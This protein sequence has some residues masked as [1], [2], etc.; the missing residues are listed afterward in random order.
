MRAKAVDQVVRL[1]GD[2]R[3][4]DLPTV[5]LALQNAVSAHDVKVLTHRGWGKPHTLSKLVHSQR[6]VEKEFNKFDAMRMRK[7]PQV[8]CRPPDH[9]EIQLC[10][11]FV[12]FCFHALNLDSMLSHLY[13]Q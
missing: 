5:A 13:I 9:L 4:E 3:V 6:V 8:R 11:G 1:R 7:H 2:N 12:R 10:S